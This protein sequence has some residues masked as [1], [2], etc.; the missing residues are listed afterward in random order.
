MIIFRTRIYLERAD[1]G[2]ILQLLEMEKKKILTLVGSLQ[3]PI[4]SFISAFTAAWNINEKLKE[5]LKYIHYFLFPSLPPQ[6]FCS[7]T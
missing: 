3:V 7:R 2:Y 5:K 4:T 1:Y 6:C